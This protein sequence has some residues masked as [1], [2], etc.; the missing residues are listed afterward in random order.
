[1]SDLTKRTSP[2]PRV[3][4][5]S[6]QRCVIFSNGLQAGVAL[7]AGDACYIDSNG[8]VQKSVSTVNS[9]STG[10]FM[11]SAFDGIVGQSYASGSIGVTLYGPGA[12]FGYAASGLTIGQHLWVS[13]TAG[14]IADAK[15][16]TNDEPIAKVISATDIIVIR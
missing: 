12:K 16:A 10:T 7:T 11:R 14:K 1:M 13:N 3:E 4:P 8:R 9:P 2:A 5:M 15:V 6:A